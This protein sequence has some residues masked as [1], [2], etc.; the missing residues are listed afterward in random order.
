MI[1]TQPLHNEF[2]A[3]AEEIQFRDEMQ[4]RTVWI[5]TRVERGRPLFVGSCGIILI[6][7]CIA[8]SFY[9]NFVRVYLHDLN[10]IAV[11]NV[12]T[13]SGVDT[14]D[15]IN[16]LQCPFCCSNFSEPYLA[17]LLVFSS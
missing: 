13:I 2:E 17:I 1:Y 6:Q 4:M 16:N 8:H 11:R 9:D 10:D 5:E 7:N 3:T 15:K 14:L 12:I